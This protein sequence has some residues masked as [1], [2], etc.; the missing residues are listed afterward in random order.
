[1]A[2]LGHPRVV[3]W[4]FAP[5][6]LVVRFEGHEGDSCPICVCSRA[7]W[8]AHTEEG[9]GGRKRL[10]LLCHNCGNRVQFELR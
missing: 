1:M 7:H 2:K 9:P 5:G 10:H 8:F 3:S 4:R 6:E